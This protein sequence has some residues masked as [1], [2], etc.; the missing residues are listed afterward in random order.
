MKSGKIDVDLQIRRS[1]HLK[2]VSLL[3]DTEGNLSRE[4]IAVG[5]LDVR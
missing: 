4:V 3:V 5:E 2:R 1:L